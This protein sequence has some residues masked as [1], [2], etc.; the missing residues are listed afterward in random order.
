MRRLWLQRLAV[1]ALG[2]LALV[3]GLELGL[4]ALAL[5]F[6]LRQRSLD[7]ELVGSEQALTVLCIGE[8][9]TAMGGQYAW[10]NQLQELLQERMP[11]KRVVVINEGTPGVDSSILLGRL[12]ANLERYQPD[13][14]AAMM[15]ANDVY[16]GAIPWKQTPMA[17][18]RGPEL[19]T[20]KLVEQLALTLRA[21]RDH[22]GSLDPVAAVR[23]N[24][25]E[26]EG[27][28][29]QSAGSW[30]DQR[31]VRRARAAAREGD[32]ER[33]LGLLQAAA[34]ERP[35]SALLHEELGVVLRFVGRLDEAEVALERAL[36]LD[37]E[38]ASVHMELAS[39]V[40][41]RCQKEE[42]STPCLAVDGQDAVE[43]HLRAALALDPT[44][45]ATWTHLIHRLQGIGRREEALATI[46]DYRERYPEGGEQVATILTTLLAE[47]GRYGDLIGVLEGS[48]EDDAGCSF[49]LPLL[50]RAY[51]EVGRA[52]DAR[53]VEAGLLERCGDDARVLARLAEHF[54]SAGEQAQLAE[55]ERR[56]HALSH[57]SYCPLT[58]RSYERLSA[59]LG[60]RGILL[61]AVQYP[62]CPIE[63]LGRYLQPRPGIV[64]VD[65]ERVFEE[66]VEREGY[67]AIFVD[68]CYGP[69][70]HATRRGNRILAEQVAAAIVQAIDPS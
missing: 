18:R 69:F 65:N 29:A 10:P 21:G 33:A 66:A 64:M 1:L 63:G 34:E 58:H 27:C 46:D 36:A 28:G 3:L 57:R 70:G 8:S 12:E 4:R 54:Q 5:G 14:V 25:V 56:L 45:E 61:V 15:G 17:E 35:E 50:A 55:V 49:D 62:T 37:P 23:W 30:S 47:A 67:D 19:K 39:V 32:P 52:T 7:P 26:G 6:A 38:A 16:T 48:F 9:T 60:D 22:E 41:A 42:R 53:T 11:A 68:H 44:R 51:R 59:S 13:I 31:V 43:R 20:W 40:S 2:C 24:R